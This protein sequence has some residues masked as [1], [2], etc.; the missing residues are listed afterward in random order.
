MRGLQGNHGQ[1]LGTPFKSGRKNTL[2]KIGRSDFAIVCKKGVAIELSGSARPFDRES[3]FAEEQESQSG[4]PSR[5][6]LGLAVR[7]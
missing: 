1:Y 7:Q 3:T 2:R 5:K 4:K 6:A